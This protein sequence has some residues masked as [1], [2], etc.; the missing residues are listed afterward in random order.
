MR[1]TLL[2]FTFCFLSF[3]PINAQ[4]APP[5]SEEGWFE[6]RGEY[7][8][9]AV[10]TGN[11][12]LNW[13]ESENVKWKS[14]IPG[15]GHSTPIIRGDQIILLAAVPTDQKAEQSSV[16][17]DAGN[18]GMSSGDTETIHRFT[19]YSVDRRNGD[20]QWATT[21]REQQP[22]S[23]N[24]QFGSWASNSPVTD[25]EKIWANF[26]SY[27]LYCLDYAGNILW[28][29]ELG[30]MEK[31][32]SFGEG[33]SPVISGEK[34]IVLRDHEGPSHM[35]VMNK[36]TGETL[37]ETD[38]DEPSSWSTPLVVG[39]KGRNQLITS[40]SN[41]VRSYDLET[42]EI[43]W[44]CAGLTSNVIPSPM[45]KDGRIYVM[46]G[47]RGNA[48]MAIDLSKAAGDITGTDAILFTFNQNTPYTPAPVLMNDRLYFLRSN[49]GYLTCLNAI[50]GTP[51]YVNEKL[52]GISEIFTSPLG[53]ADRL[54]VLGSNGTCVVVRSGDTFG[55]MARNQ[56]DDGFIASPVVVGDELFLRGNQY[57]YCIAD[58]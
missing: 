48:L 2:L 50:D 1:T 19:V 29:K 46:S 42:G 13:S 53:V 49:N 41:K 38:R 4:H 30:R 37:W 25:G 54:Y 39:Y 45:Y 14:A 17:G 33:S 20:I 9:G 43:I 18:Q 58:Q 10:P 23:G 28:E 55:V 11:P 44:E 36:Q 7:H 16:S 22:Y 24:H 8:R 15:T 27:G 40:A 56:L 35:L 3:Q 26:G 51:F 34:L 12:P 57:L 5:L 47:H 52:E 32:N 31:R 6:W 21:V